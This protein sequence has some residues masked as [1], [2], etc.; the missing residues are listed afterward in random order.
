MQVKRLGIFYNK[1][2]IP[3]IILQYKYSIQN[4]WCQEAKSLKPDKL[5]NITY[6]IPIGYVLRFY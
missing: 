2:E 6:L 4:G 3:L 1:I 5:I